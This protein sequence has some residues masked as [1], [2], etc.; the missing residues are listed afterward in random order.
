MTKF[1]GYADNF[2]DEFQDEIIFCFRKVNR[3][4]VQKLGESTRRSIGTI[5]RYGIVEMR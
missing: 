3:E 2:M 5:K 4:C 1:A